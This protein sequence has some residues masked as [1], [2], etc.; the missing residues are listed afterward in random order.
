[1]HTVEFKTEV[2]NGIIEI[3]KKYV[4]KPKYNVKVILLT[5]E[6]VDTDYDIIDELLESPVKLPDFRPLKREEIYD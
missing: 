5:E 6:S 2:I 4:K 3:P 1:M